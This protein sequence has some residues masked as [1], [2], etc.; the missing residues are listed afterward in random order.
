MS[1]ELYEV[2]QGETALYT[3][4]LRD[5]AGAAIASANMV[6]LTLDLFDK[7]SGTQ[8][9]SR[10]AQ[11]VLNTNNVT[12]HATSG[13]MSWEIQAADSVIVGTVTERRSE[14]HNARFTLT[15]DTDKVLVFEI[16]IVVI[17][18]QTTVAP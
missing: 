2:N 8:I 3:A 10:A 14:I 7:S 11:D 16:P 5:T 6:S 18:L 1:Q 17:K 12:V 9:N 4:T 15:Y 13:L